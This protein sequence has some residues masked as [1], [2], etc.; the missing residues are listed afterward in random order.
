MDIVFLF[1]IPVT[2]IF[3]DELIKVTFGYPVKFPHNLN[4]REKS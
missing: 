1:P 3:H 4:Y 2:R